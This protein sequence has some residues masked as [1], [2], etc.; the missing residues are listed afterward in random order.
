[1][2]QARTG[3]Y[4]RQRCSANGPGHPCTRWGTLLERT[5]KHWCY[6][7]DGDLSMVLDLGI[8]ILHP[9]EPTRVDIVDA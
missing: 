5:N 7:S 2:W 6:H 3:R 4:C 8:D 9:A 1:M